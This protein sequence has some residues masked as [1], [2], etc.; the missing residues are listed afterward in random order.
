VTV[1]GVV[2]ATIDLYSPSTV[3]KALVY[4]GT[5]PLGQHLIRVEAVGTSTGAN[6]SINV[7]RITIN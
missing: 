1:D 2:K 7:D 4:S 3:Y 6:S 5:I